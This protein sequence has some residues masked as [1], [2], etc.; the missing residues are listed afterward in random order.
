MPLQKVELAPGFN[1]QATASQAEAQWVDGDNVR[2]RYASPEK[3][4]G[5]DQQTPDTLVGA[6]RAVTTWSDTGGTKYAA[7]GT[8]KMLAIYSGNAFYDITPLANTIATC[9][10]TSTTGSSTVTIG[11]SAHGLAEGALLIFDNVT[12]PA[13]CSFTTGDFETNTFEIQAINTNDF[14]VVMTSTETGGGASA[15]AGLDT[16]PYEVVGP[17]NQTFQYGWGTGS[18]S[19]STWGT[20][21]TSSQI[22]L[23]P[24]TWSL[25]NFGEKLVATIH[26]GK[27][28]IWDP[29]L[30][31]PLTRRAI[32]A[33]NNPTKSV[34]TIVSDRDRHLIHLG[35]ETT[36]GT[37]STQDQMYLRFSDQEDETDYVPTST[38]TAGTMYLDQGNKIMGAVQGKDYILI[39]T[40]TAA[41]IMQYVG[42]PITFSI[43]QVGSDCGLIGQHAIV[44]ANGVIFWMGNGGGFFMFD[45]SVKPVPCLVEDFVFTT[46]GDNLGIN[47]DTGG[48]LVFAGHNALFNEVSWFYP[49]ATADQIN[50]I[51]TYN[52]MESVWATG[53]LDRTTWS[54][55]DIY[56]LPFATEYESGSK[57]TLPTINGVTNGRS[58]FYEHET[59]SDQIRRYSTGNVTSAISSSIRSGDFDLDVDGDGQYFMSL[60]RF[61]PDFKHLNGTANVTIYLRRFPN[62]TATTSPLGPFTVSTS[63]EQIWTRARS[64]LAS[65]EVSADELASNW[66]YGLFR[67]DS[68]PDGMR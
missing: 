45:G 5:W 31:S 12:I 32:I 8:H 2:F 60:R 39:L 14:N 62:D 46:D 11:K 4:G 43:R 64:R 57:P 23:D 15:G 68:R 20:A 67:F 44:Y 33:A 3:I 22:I 47:Y 48:E 26:N 34:M 19:T 35:T 36:I 65:F 59:G 13:G 53:T 49:Q 10:I 9:T 21:R 40:D 41:Y 1:K 30:A 25:D 63:T 55:P 52:Y 24:G 54:N 18:Y 51:V 7:V 27:T 29:S 37:T 66:R 58:I 16:E 56:A 17:V 38:N 28:F 42:P 6:A 61:I 50:R